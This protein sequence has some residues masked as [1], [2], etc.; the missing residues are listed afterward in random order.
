MWD[1]YANLST[2]EFEEDLLEV[3]TEFIFGTFTIFS[4]FNGRT[5][6]FVIY[7]PEIL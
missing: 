3:L 4:I 5:N 7:T 1:E 6:L 2:M